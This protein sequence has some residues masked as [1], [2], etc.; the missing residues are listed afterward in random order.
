M[1]LNVTDR[2]Y[3]YLFSR[4]EFGKGLAEVRNLVQ[5]VVDFLTPASISFI[6]ELYA[7][8][9]KDFL[10]LMSKIFRASYNNSRLDYIM[11]W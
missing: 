2:T 8:T 3:R 4:Y 9:L 5:N 6:N 11:A 10:F 1:Y 7:S